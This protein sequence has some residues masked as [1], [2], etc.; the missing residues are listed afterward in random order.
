MRRRLVRE[1]MTPRGEVVYLDDSL[2]FRDNFQRAKAA[3]HTRFPLCVEHFDHTIGLV[4]I[5]DI[6]A[7]VDKPEPSLLTIK[8]ELLLVSEM[9]PLA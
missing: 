2:S 6:L 1:V 4:H 7:E 5:K 9:I 3:R 8:R